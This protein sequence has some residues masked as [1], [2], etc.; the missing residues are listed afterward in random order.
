MNIKDFLDLIIKFSIEITPYNEDFRLNILKRLNEIVPCSQ[1]HFVFTDSDWSYSD[2]I[3]FKENNYRHFF[4]TE[5]FKKCPSHPQVFPKLFGKDYSHLCSSVLTNDMLISTTKFENLDFY[6]EFFIVEGMHYFAL[7][8]FE[9]PN[10]KI[11]TIAL[12]RSKSMGAFSDNETL[13]L[14]LLKPLVYSRI[15]EYYE[16]SY[17]Q[18]V[19]KIMSYSIVNS[20]M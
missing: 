3:A 12:L 4:D 13:L 1:L 11:A 8:H 16:V 10:K 17:I 9:I 15:M 6:K 20:S 14:E 7:L 5:F 18:H 19:K 2:S